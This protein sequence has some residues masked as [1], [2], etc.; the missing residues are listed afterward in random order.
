MTRRILMLFVL[1]FCFAIGFSQHPQRPQRPPR[2]PFDPARFEVELEQFIV[3]EACLTPHESSL[4]F[5]LYREMRRHQLG[6]LGEMRRDRYFDFSDDKACSEV[7]NESD[8]RDV[9]MKRLQQEYHK[10]FMKVLPASKVFRIIRA[11]DKFHRKV[12]KR[13]AIHDEHR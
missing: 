4:F 8:N 2:P 9:E 13:A 6:F 5:P 7:I 10:K 11:E 3:T 12:F 1:T